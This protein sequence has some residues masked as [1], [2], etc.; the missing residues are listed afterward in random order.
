MLRLDDWI[1][2]PK[3]IK[4]DFNMRTA[5]AF[6][7]RSIYGQSRYRRQNAFSAFAWKI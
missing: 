2:E 3:F 7:T 5:A 1:T 6:A 4:R